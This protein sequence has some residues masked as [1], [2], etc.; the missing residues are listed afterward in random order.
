MLEG[1]ARDLQERRHRMVGQEFTF[2]G[3]I[4]GALFHVCSRS[5]AL[6]GAGA[7]LDFAD[8]ERCNRADDCG[9]I[10]RMARFELRKLSFPLLA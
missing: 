7:G 4:D 3:Y 5:L 10:D 6:C 8:A 2:R 1:D 9:S